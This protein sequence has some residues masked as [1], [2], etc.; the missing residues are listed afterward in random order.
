IGVQVG[1]IARFL[2]DIK[3]GDF[4]ITPPTDTEF[5]NYGIVDPDPSYFYFEGKDGCPYPHR[6]RISWNVKTVRRSDFS[7]PFQNTIRS[8]LTVY[9]ISHTDHFFEVIGRNDLVGRPRQDVFDSYKAALDHLLELTPT[10]F[11]ILI[12]HLLAALGFEGTEHTGK[13]GDG[14]VDATG[15]LNV[16][17]LAK[18]KIFVQ[19]KR[20][21][22]GSK[23][24]ANTVKALR[25]SIPS[26]GQGAFITTAD[27]HNAASDIALEVGFPRIGLINGRQLVDLLI[28]YWADI[29]NEFK[30][31]LGLKLG[32]VPA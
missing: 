19:V 32:L 5:L 24:S 27:F 3:G 7:V 28:E 22:L 11:E 16:A 29:P 25:Q 2:L 6:R 23:I 14:G 12:T 4:V 13:T 31:K 18:I 8:S 20:Y 1:Q 26:G 17:N 30:E 10:E 9:N 15:E 21:Q